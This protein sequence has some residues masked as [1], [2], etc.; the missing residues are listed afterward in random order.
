MR[1]EPPGST[2][3]PGYLLPA[4]RLALSAPPKETVEIG[5]D[6]ICRNAPYALSIA[7]DSRGS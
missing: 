6:V 1:R 3:G 7:E 5:Y 2:G 4:R